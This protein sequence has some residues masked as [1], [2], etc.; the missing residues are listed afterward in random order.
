MRSIRR[1]LVAIRQP[2]GRSIAAVAKA[3]QLARAL[4][5]DLELFHAI[6]TPIRVTPMGLARFGLEYFEGANIAVCRRQL[7]R[8]AARVR[9]RGLKVTAAADFDFPSYEAILRRAKRVKA[10]LIIADCHG[11]QRAARALLRLTDWELLRLSP[12]PVLLVKRAGAYPRRPALLAALDPTHAFSKPAGLDEEILR[13]STVVAEAL[14]GTLHAVHAYVSHPFQGL[15]VGAP[16]ATTLTKMAER[17]EAQAARALGRA[18]RP[19]NIPRSRQHLLGRHPSD[20]IQSVSRKIHSDIVVMGAISRSGL[21]RLFIGN[22]AEDVL[23]TLPCDL[24][25]VKPRRFRSQLRPAKRGPH[26]YMTP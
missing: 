13:V 18:V 23:D 19:A 2:V 10:D 1:I 25:I 21:K 24:L 9:E 7:E 17:T 16:N 20:A 3:A 5:A 6:D 26:M 4:G 15:T 8:T 11:G 12:V 14:H 22:T